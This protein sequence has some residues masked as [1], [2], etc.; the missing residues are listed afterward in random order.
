MF[1][2]D[3]YQWLD[4]LEARTTWESLCSEQGK[5]SSA[6]LNQLR[7][8]FP[9]EHASL[10]ME[11]WELCSL[12]SRKVSDPE[13]WFW[14]RQLLEQ[15]SDEATAQETAADFDPGTKVVDICC[16]AGADS[17]ALAKRGANV[18][19]IDRCPIACWLASHN[20]RQ[21][22]VSIDVV[23]QAAEDCILQPNAFIHIDPDRRADGSRS[24]QFERL[25]PNWTTI[26]KMLESC[27]GMSLKLGPG[28]RIAW[29]QL[30]QQ[31]D[32]PPESIRFIAKDGTVRQQR[33]SWGLGRWPRN[34]ITVSMLLNERSR[35][36]AETFSELHTNRNDA[37]TLYK[38][39]WFH[40][41]FLQSTMVRHVGDVTVDQVGDYVA[42]YDPSLRAAELSPSFAARYGW[43]LLHSGSGY[44][45]SDRP[46]IH[47]LVRWYRVL[48]NVPLDRKHL[49]VLSKQLSVKRWELKSRGVDVDLDAMRK[50]LVTDRASE[51]GLSIL[52]T[53][54]GDSHRALICDE[55]DVHYA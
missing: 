41:T 6:V 28:H 45:S 4:S 40:E 43:N 24:N 5:S 35:K 13:R 34:S 16:G 44:L 1:S 7:A 8:K 20:A 39:N 14:T 11:Q 33:W 10:L 37:E 52:F 54:I 26:S 15:A 25:S 27:K 18:Q 49:K 36:N 3:N 38:E 51:R 22:R 9:V 29:N 31:V 12:A 48:E 55:T 32:H 30:P 2:V 53:E 46:T 23:S 19:S 21:Q 47:P 17:I 42:D 50:I